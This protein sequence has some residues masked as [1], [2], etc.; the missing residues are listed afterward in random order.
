MNDSKIAGNS[1]YICIV[2]DIYSK[3][4][5]LGIWIGELEGVKFRILISNDK[6]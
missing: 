3:K 6:K 5:I 1:P 2:L 4:D